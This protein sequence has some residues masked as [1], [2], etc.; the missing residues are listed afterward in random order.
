MGR[1]IGVDIRYET[2]LWQLKLGRNVRNFNEGK[3]FLGNVL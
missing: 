1:E 2:I 3:C